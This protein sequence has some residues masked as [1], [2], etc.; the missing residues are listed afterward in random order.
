MASPYFA[1]DFARHDELQRIELLE[2]DLDPLTFRRLRA[3]GVAQGWR[4]LDVGAGGGSVARW[5]AGV[6][7][8]NGHVTAMDVDT[9]FLTRVDASG[10]EVRKHD[11]LAGPIEPGEYDL[12]HCRYL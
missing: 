3:L 9:E 4:C 8:P 7:A 2:A 12:V 6:V 5:L 11:V 10:I 1:A